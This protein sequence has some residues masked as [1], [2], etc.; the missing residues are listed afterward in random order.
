MKKNNYIE[1]LRFL[2]CSIIVVHHSS[3]LFPSGAF[4][5]EFF[6]IVMGYF[7][8]KHIE[9]DGTNFGMTSSAKYTVNK[10]LRLAPYTTIAIIGAYLLEFFQDKSMSL[11]DRIKIFQN[12]MKRYYQ[13]IF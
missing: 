2:F 13:L 12:L 7:A 8:I 3:N 5:V 4:A 10:L 9:D 6:Y 1:F 11:V